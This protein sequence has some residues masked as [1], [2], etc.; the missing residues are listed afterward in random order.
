MRNTK[1]T[2]G[3]IILLIF[4]FTTN[5]YGQAC[6]TA[7][8][9]LLGSLELTSTPKGILQ[10]GMT[11]DHNSLTDV[12][13]GSETLRNGE[14]ERI[15]QS[16]LFELNYG[17]SNNITITTLLSY[18]RQQRTIFNN[19]STNEL[20][21]S[22]IGDIVL[23]GKYSLIQS[24]IFN[25]EEL[26]LGL[27]FKIPTGSSS[28]KANGILI[29]ADMQPG[30]GSWDGILWGIYSKGNIITNNLTLLTNVSLRLNG[31]NARFGNSNE[32][33]SFGNEFIAMAGFSYP[34]HSLLELTLLTKFRSTRQDIFADAQIPNTG[35]TWINLKPSLNIYLSQKLS[36]RI[37]GEL[38]IY[39]EVEGTQLTT[40]YS[41]SVSLFYAYN[42]F[43]GSFR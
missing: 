32:G 40:T 6:C 22:G 16:V 15:S 1:S 34:I 36:T 10:L 23:L 31:N 42:F 43:E 29:P 27:G 11:A 12:L 41:A 38:P 20:T 3:L 39:G 18:I 24:D 4:L 5:I 37:G 25:N 7:G 26:S 19:N 17:I 2:Y 13:S 33:Y 14:R 28:I 30:T 9:P 35:G 8:T 21:A